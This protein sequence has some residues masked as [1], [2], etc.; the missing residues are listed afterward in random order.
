M[1]KFIK[2]IIIKSFKKKKIIYSGAGNS[3]SKYIVF[4]DSMLLET[5]SIGTGNLYYNTCTWHL[6]DSI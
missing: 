4:N 5:N 2:N 3:L 1:I 6:Y